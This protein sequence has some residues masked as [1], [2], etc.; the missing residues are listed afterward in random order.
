MSRPRHLVVARRGTALLVAAVLAACGIDQGGI[1]RPP[2]LPQL[3]VI[4]GPITGFGSI[5]VNGLVLDTRAAQI[6]V[7][8]GPAVETD[9]R[10]GQVIRAIALVGPGANQALSIEYQSNLVGPI[11]ALDPAAS[12]L[13]VL[14]QRVL[15]N[16]A[17]ALDLGQGAAFADLQL[18]E[19]L[20][21]SGLR[22][23]TGEILATYVGRAAPGSALRIT[24]SITAADPAGLTF[25]IG[26]LTVDYSQVALLQVP[27]GVPQPGAVVAVTGTTELGGALV[28]MQVST[29][30]F[31]ADSLAAS[32][33]ALTS[34][35]TPVVSAA[36]VSSPRAA[37]FMGFITASTPGAVALADV[38][39]AVGSSTAIIGG[40][41]NSLPVGA[42]VLVEGR[43]VGFGQVE[44]DRITIL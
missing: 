7:D 33:T 21:V 6:R 8:G 10:R 39:V 15:L 31:S 30:P 38:D 44:A 24:G 43:I 22:T 11:V 13:T 12:T 18:T 42:L 40:E 27:N 5:H 3:T 1:E 17:T 41:G 2:E 35:E 26:G 28:A 34:V 36:T 19:Q 25:E 20:V 29:P 14:G 32:A 16:A 37:N 9:L 23:P 4:S